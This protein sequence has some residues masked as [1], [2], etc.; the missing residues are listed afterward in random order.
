MKLSKNKVLYVSLITTLF[1]ANVFAS[2]EPVPGLPFPSSGTTLHAATTTLAG[3]NAAAAGAA[4]DQAADAADQAADAA[5]NAKDAA[6]DAK[7]AASAAG[8]P[9]APSN[10]NNDGY[11]TRAYKG[12]K[13]GVYF[14]GTSGANGVKWLFAT[15]TKAAITSVALIAAA[16]LTIYYFTSKGE[17]HPIVTQDDLDN[18]ED[19]FEDAADKAERQATK[20]KDSFKK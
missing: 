6:K 5:D 17:A 20:T 3:N 11:F 14:V 7:D 10:P 15:K 16:G 18:A 1:T 2:V 12:T 9:S 13:N 8:V 4:A 19:D